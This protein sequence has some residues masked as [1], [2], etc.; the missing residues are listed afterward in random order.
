MINIPTDFFGVQ[1]SKGSNGININLAN[2]LKKSGGKMYGPI[3]MNRNKLINLN[4]PEH[5]S[6]SSN[7]AYVDKKINELIT[8][9]NDVITLISELE[10]KLKICQLRGINL[11]FLNHW[12]Y[13]KYPY[14]FACHYNDIYMKLKRLTLNILLI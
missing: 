9:N 10:N 4:A 13:R 2:F 1:S 3:D 7:K 5:P 11:R 14:S 12:F 8:L 6:E